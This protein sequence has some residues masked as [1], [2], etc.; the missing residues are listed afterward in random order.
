MKFAPLHVITGYSFL[1]SGLTTSKIASSV[2]SFDYYG[3]GVS[4]NEV[5][6]GLAPLSKE[7]KSVNKPFLFV[8]QFSI[9]GD[10]L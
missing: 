5:M 1:T 6:Y 10:I 9:N 4:D 7:M 2:K 8:E 3:V